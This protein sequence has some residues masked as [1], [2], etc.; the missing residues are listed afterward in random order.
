[1]THAPHQG[2]RL[3]LD[4][5]CEECVSRSKDL[6]GLSQLD[7]GNLRKLGGLA[8]AIH[9]NPGSEDAPQELGASY[10]DRNAVETLRLA[11][12]IVYRSRITEEVA[13]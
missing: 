7:N 8:H 12:R 1:M 2:V 5:D 10:A 3:V 9:V 4:D 13:R 6:Y 11:A